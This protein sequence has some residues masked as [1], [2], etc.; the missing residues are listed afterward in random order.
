MKKEGRQKRQLKE[1]LNFR[2]GDAIDASMYV[3]K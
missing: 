2:M 3:T 1:R